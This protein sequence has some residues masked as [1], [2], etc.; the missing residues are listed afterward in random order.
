VF[1]SSVSELLL[2]NQ[3]AIEV[4]EHYQTYHDCG[5]PFCMVM[6]DNRRHFPNHAEVSYQVYQQHFDSD[7]VSLL[8]LNDMKFHTLRGSDL[9]NW[10]QSLSYLPIKMAASLYLTAWAEII[11]NSR[12]F[13]GK[14]STSFKIKKKALIAASN[15]LIPFLTA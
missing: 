7:V 8:I 6:V 12:M 5:K 10:L 9:A 3:F 1:S 15:K 14:D 13:G 2:K 11:S 4:M